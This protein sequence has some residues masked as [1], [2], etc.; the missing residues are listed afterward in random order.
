MTANILIIHNCCAK[1]NVGN[2]QRPAS[3]SVLTH[4]VRNPV[5]NIEMACDMLNQT[6]LS[7]YQKNFVDIILRS[8]RRIDELTNAVLQSF[9]ALDV[10]H[11]LYSIQQLLDEVLMMLD[12]RIVQRQ[13]SVI[14]EYPDPEDGIMLDVRKTKAALI[15]IIGH[16]I[17]GMPPKGGKLKLSTRPLGEMRVIEIQQ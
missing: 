8:S 12:S 4:E 10:N 15:N 1:S 2:H 5:G 13:I 6:G 14:R 11:E 17:D 3:V 7:P 16:A 9:G